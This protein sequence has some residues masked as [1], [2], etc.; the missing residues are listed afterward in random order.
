M[1]WARAGFR[2]GPHPPPLNKVSVTMCRQAVHGI[3]TCGPRMTW[4][5]TATEP[6]LM[7]RPP[8]VPDR[9]SAYGPAARQFA[10]DAA[11]FEEPS[12]SGDQWVDGR[13]RGDAAPGRRI[14]QCRGV[15]GRIPVMSASP[16]GRRIGRR[17]CDCATG[18]LG[19]TSTVAQWRHGGPDTVA[20]RR[21][22]RFLART[23]QDPRAYAHQRRAVRHAAVVPGMGLWASVSQR[24]NAA[25]PG[26]L[27]TGGWASH[28][29]RPGQGRPR[30]GRRVTG[31]WRASASLLGW[32]PM[33]G[34]PRA[35]GGRVVGTRPSWVSE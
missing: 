8:R 18:G 3:G 14:D 29:F 23:P 17:S 26:Q 35:S 12:R 20:T 10:P 9:Q 11:G 7:V 5:R 19:D 31:G 30:P 15:R 24:D 21:P 13:V 32:R 25:A 33:A 2:L 22:G 27:P 16:G 4:L 28:R 34:A 1:L 6:V